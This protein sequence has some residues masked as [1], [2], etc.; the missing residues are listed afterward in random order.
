MVVFF[1]V[2][3]INSKNSYFYNEDHKDCIKD[4]PGKLMVYFF[5]K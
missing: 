2:K 1:L 3:V 4:F 5:K